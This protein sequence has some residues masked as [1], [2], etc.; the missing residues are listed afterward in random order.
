MQQLY[1]QKGLGT[2]TRK[3]RQIQTGDA[4]MTTP[5]LKGCIL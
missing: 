1:G 2:I 3:I 4:Y 5:Y